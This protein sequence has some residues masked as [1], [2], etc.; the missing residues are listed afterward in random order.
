MFLAFLF[1]GVFTSESIF[2]LAFCYTFYFICPLLSIHFLFSSFHLT[3]T[4]K[5]GLSIQ[6][7]NNPRGY[8]PRT[9]IWIQVQNPKIRIQNPNMRVQDYT[10][11]LT[12]HWCLTKFNHGKKRVIFSLE[13]SAPLPVTSQKKTSQTIWR[14][15][16]QPPPPPGRAGGAS[17]YKTTV[18]CDHSISSVFW[19]ITCC[20]YNTT[21]PANEIKKWLSVENFQRWMRHQTSAMPKLE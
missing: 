4:L 15:D 20:S 10:P 7:A 14:G 17:H 5:R 8:V 12:D 2:P 6:T 1:V 13:H 18:W 9:S 19:E 21:L 16:T 3:L 11:M